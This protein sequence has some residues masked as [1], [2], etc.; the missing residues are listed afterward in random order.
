MVSW[1]PV[2]TLLG[3]SGSANNFL[4][5][6]KKLKL[7][8]FIL[9]SATSNSILPTAMIGIFTDFFA[10]LANSINPP[11]SCTKGPSVKAIPILLFPYALTSNASAPA[12]S[13]ICAV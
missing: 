10:S 2:I 5:K 8:L 7:P 6:A 13:A 1:A 12:F 3:N 4:P 9:F 11:G